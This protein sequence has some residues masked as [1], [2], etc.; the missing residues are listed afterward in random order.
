MK[1][2]VFK[3]YLKRTLTEPVGIGIV[4]GLPTL[5][6]FILTSV[7]MGQIPEDVPYMWQGYNMVSTHI[8]IM[9][10]VSFQFFGGNVLLDHIH[11]DFR[12][13]RRWRMFSMPVKTNDYVF[14]IL[15]AC[16][17]FCIVQ[18]ALVIGI[19]A[20]FLDVYWGNLWVLIA[21]LFACAGLAQLLYMLLFL[22]LPK[23]G[24]V[25]G[26]VQVIIFAMMFASGW[27]GI[28]MDGTAGSTG[29]AFNNFFTQY[30][31]PISLARNAITNS[32]FLGNDMNNAVLSVGILYVLLT[33]LA[34]TVALIG[35]HKG[36]AP[37]KNAVAASDISTPIKGLAR[38]KAKA[39]QKIQDIVDTT[40]QKDLLLT[41]PSEVHGSQ[42][43]IIKYALLRIYRNPVSLILNAALPLVAIFI[44]DLWQ[45]E[46]PF[47]F[48]IIGV[49]LMYGSFTAARG[50]L[51][52]KLDG[53]ITRILTSPITFFQYLAQN[54]MAAMMPLMA[55]ILAVGI[56]GGMLY[57]WET[58]FTLSVMLIYLLF[59]AASVAF[60]YAWSCLFKEK[61]TSYAIFSVLMSLVAMVGGFFIPLAILPDVLR[62]VGALFP[63]FWVSNGILYLQGGNAMGTY[64]VSIAALIMFSMLYMVLGSKR[65]II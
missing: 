19:S 26:L 32:G 34:V 27:I 36:F 51:N 16:F 52:D 59:A 28:N 57:G 61:E 53:T 11:A 22:L 62:Y 35:K 58:G 14:G 47:G 64:W 33:V 44:P 46:G 13:D 56:I 6:I 10:M 23:K 30:G 7:I 2:L 18:G 5:L 21:T 48:S 49:A 9:F 40:K 50:I 15:M 3:H 29:K 39:E 25:E 41:T 63:A 1:G 42:L 43:T 45:G 4:T 8:A 60:L 55:Q 38:K 37:S 31:T 20:V 17:V 54:L 65:R 24:T 12:G